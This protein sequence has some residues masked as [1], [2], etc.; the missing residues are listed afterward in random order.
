MKTRKMSHPA[1]LSFDEILKFMLANNGKVT[2][3]ELVKHFKV[4]LMNPDMRGKLLK[5]ENITRLSN[6]MMRNIGIIV[7]IRI[8]L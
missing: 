5:L 3:H 6:F 7:V 1:E 8:S 4:F 2:N